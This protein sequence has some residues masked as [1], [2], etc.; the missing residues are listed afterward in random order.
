MGEQKRKESATAA[1]STAG[2]SIFARYPD[3]KLGKPKIKY[4]D[5]TDLEMVVTN[6]FK[7]I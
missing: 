7:K 3:N 1:Q 6:H 4:E 2:A 5:T